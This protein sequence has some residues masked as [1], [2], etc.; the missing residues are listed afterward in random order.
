MPPPGEVVEA[1]PEHQRPRSGPPQRQ[2]GLGS[3]LGFGVAVAGA[4]SLG[5]TAF[6]AGPALELPTIEAYIFV[7][8]HFSIDISVPIFNTIV[9]A[10]AAGIGV[11]RADVYADFSIGDDWVRFVV[12]PGLGFS[13]GDF[14]NGRFTTSQINIDALVGVE[15]LSVSRLFGFRVQTRPFLGIAFVSSSSGVGVGGGALL[16][17]ALAWYVTNG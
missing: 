11:F 14:G 7:D 5:A 13:Y 8:D 17:L 6:A 12:G 9:L 2:F 15:L 1:P 10:A 3:T 16:E 4:F